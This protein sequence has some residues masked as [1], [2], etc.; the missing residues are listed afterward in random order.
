MRIKRIISAI[1]I[2]M[3]KQHLV[4]VLVMY[5]SSLFGMPNICQAQ[6]HER[7]ATVTSEVNKLALWYTEPATEWTE[8]LPIGNGRTVQ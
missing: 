2:E 7:E 3:K 1:F 6:R 4:F 5:L 8:A